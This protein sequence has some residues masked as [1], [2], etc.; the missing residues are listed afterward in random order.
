MQTARLRVCVCACVRAT[1]GI[2]SYA[3]CGVLSNVI[4]RNVHCSFPVARCLFSLTLMCLF[5]FHPKNVITCCDINIEP[6]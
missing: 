1:Y 4:C 6:D 3:D 5:L 2:M